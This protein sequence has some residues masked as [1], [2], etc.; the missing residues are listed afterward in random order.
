MPRPAVCG[1]PDRPSERPKASVFCTM[2]R[3]ISPK[4]SVTMAR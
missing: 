1:M 2:T 3:M 4:P